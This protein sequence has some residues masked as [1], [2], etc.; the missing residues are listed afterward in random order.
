[1]SEHPFRTFID[2]IQFDQETQALRQDL[3]ILENEISEL[4]RK[5]RKL[6]AL[7]QE[8]KNSVAFLKKEVDANELAMKELDQQEAEKKKRLDEVSGPR[9]L[10]S[11]QSELAAVNR[12]QRELEDQLVELWNKYEAAKKYS[13]SQQKESAE[14]SQK[15]DQT[16]TEKKSSM[17][18]IVGQIEKREKD[19]QVREKGLPEE[20]LESYATMRAQ[21]TNPVVPIVS[22]S[23]SAC[24]YPV[25][26]QDLLM[27]KAGKLV[28]CKSCYRLLFFKELED[29]ATHEK[30]ESDEQK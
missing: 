8:A 13:D 18:E 11:I 23:C 5:K 25:S 19:R 9:E 15:F 17:S 20:W 6:D 24:F 26:R 7:L 27:L 14:S 21:V 22:D 12:K 4:E 2:L 28:Q 30:K 1:M 16:I 3:T 10:K 29:Q